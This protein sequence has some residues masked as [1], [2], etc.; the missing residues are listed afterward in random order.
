MVRKTTKQ[1]YATACWAYITETLKTLKA[2]SN[3]PVKMGQ[4]EAIYKDASETI[5][6]LSALEWVEF[7]EGAFYTMRQYGDKVFTGK[8]LG[9]FI[10][11]DE[12]TALRFETLCGYSQKLFYDSMKDISQVPLDKFVTN[13]LK[14]ESDEINKES[15]LL[16]MGTTFSG[17]LLE[18]LVKDFNTKGV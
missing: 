16:Y 5:L 11:S 1:E 10:D 9:M 6:L 7:K 18:T 3:N 13:G 17:S 15:I 4:R 12:Q 2:L 14:F 8:Y